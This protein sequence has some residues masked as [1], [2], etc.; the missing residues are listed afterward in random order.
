MQWKNLRDIIERRS[1]FK[2][3]FKVLKY[4]L[5]SHLERVGKGQEEKQT[6]SLIQWSKVCERYKTII[7]HNPR[8]HRERWT[9]WAW[10]SLLLHITSSKKEIEKLCDSVSLIGV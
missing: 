8:Y 1:M 7:K 4:S 5:D 3:F 9:R 10:E 6:S 2:F